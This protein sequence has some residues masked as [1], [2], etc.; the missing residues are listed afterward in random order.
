MPPRGSFLE[1]SDANWAV[2]D[3]LWRAPVGIALLDR[4]LSFLSVNDALARMAGVPAEGAA[5]RA[6]A[7]LL[8][9]IG[10]RL[11][12][13]RR[14]LLDPG[15]PLEDVEVG[16]EGPERDL[17]ASAYP[18]RGGPGGEVT[19]VCLVVK[20]AGDRRRREETAQRER[21]R[22]E[23]SAE[24][25]VRL[26]SLSSALARAVTS[27]EVA[28]AL[29]ERGA[30][31]T[32][33]RT[34]A[35]ASLGEGALQVTAT[36]GY[37]AEYAAAWRR[38]G[39]ELQVPMAE[40][41]RTRE[42]VWL[43][44]TAELLERYPH[45]AHLPRA[46]GLA[47]WA[48]V[49]VAVE[50]RALGALELGFA[51]PRAFPEEERRFVLALAREGADAL[52]RARRFEAEERLR[53]AAEEEAARA[54]RS[55]EKTARLQALTAALSAAVT[56]AK[57]ARLVFEQGLPLVEAK[58]GHIAWVSAR[59]ELET[60]HTF[61]YPEGAFE[62]WTRFPVTAPLPDAE[63]FR[64]GQPLWLETPQELAARFPHLADAA[65]R[66]GDRAWVTMPLVAEEQAL[67]SLGLA[68]AEP[69]R[70][71]PEERA[72]IAEVA[73]QCAVALSRARL[74]DDQRDHR[75]RAEGEAVRLRDSQR[76]RERMA[77]DLARSAE[78]RDLSRALVEGLFDAS[79]VGLAVVGPDLRVRRVNRALAPGGLAAADGGGALTV[80]DLFPGEAPERLEAS[81][82][83]VLE[84]GEPALDVELAPG[85]PGAAAGARRLCS[86][87]RVSIA[88]GVAGAG[89][90]V[91]AL[92][93]ARDEHDFERHLLG[94]VG[95]DLRNPL[96]ALSA[97]ARVLARADLSEAHANVVAKL[98]ASAAR[99]ESVVRDLLDYTRIRAG[100][101][102]LEVR[103]AHLGEICQAVADELQAAHP[104]RRVRLESEGDGLGEWDPDRLAQ[105][106]GNL[107]ANALKY[108]TP[109]KPVVLRWRGAGD[110]VR[111]E[112]ESHGPPI[113][114]ELQATLFEPFRNGA[115]VEGPRG[116]L[117]LGLYLARELV[118]AHGGR[119]E[120]SSDPAV[121][122][123]VVV[124][125]RR[126][127]PRQAA[128]VP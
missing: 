51:T 42:P 116:S 97:S 87:F 122:R 8:P 93:R 71:A 17:V 113:P 7:D 108:A 88:S 12:E 20:E 23:R 62:P 10:A 90:V 82:R 69:R 104:G 117:G 52:E 94:I 34:A 46:Y 55:A 63:A 36:S 127:V 85:P 31:L 67:G 106:L 9:R 40:A 11:L 37:P 50:G 41:F 27:A 81:V 56:P 98:E 111:V 109:E 105:A 100:Q 76:E 99:M 59:G 115:R 61:G 83:R 19:S 54:R 89:A 13:R 65:E 1:R 2:L 86:W 48:V 49:P 74:F 18:V 5:G 57:V 33:A 103:P 21:L 22:A 114:P 53:I 126:T 107:V 120:V 16:G 14:R 35:F 92:P 96:A 26:Q 32:G 101:V 43:A 79:P 119:V 64:S 45:L 102:A 25:V 30:A 84:T 118:E 6:V 29:A 39:R 95:H 24:T 15:D 125:P 28:R 44:S 91:H 75:N 80:R 4:E 124:L 66:L 128:S 70:F 121:T 73:R 38:F 58:A 60:V 112:V 110:E 72:F 3:S 47:A 77:A 123:F 68:F 78:Q